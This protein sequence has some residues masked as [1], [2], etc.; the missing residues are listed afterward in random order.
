VAFNGEAT[1]DNHVAAAK[2]EI[3]EILFIAV[4]VDLVTTGVKLFLHTENVD[5][6]ALH[7]C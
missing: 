4:G 7:L 1:I 6:V 3:G 2:T 5:I